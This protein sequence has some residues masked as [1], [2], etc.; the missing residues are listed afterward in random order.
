MGEGVLIEDYLTQVSNDSSEESVL[1]RKLFQ[2]DLRLFNSS[3]GYRMLVLSSINYMRAVMNLEFENYPEIQGISGA[4][5]GIPFNVIGVKK[6]K[7]RRG[8]LFMINPRVV[9]ESKKKTEVVTNCGSVNLKRPV[10]VKRSDWVVVSYYDEDGNFVSGETFRGREGNT[11]QHEIDHNLG[12]LI[13]DG[14]GEEER[15]KK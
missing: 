5:V 6:V 1:R 8:P 10:K 12:T 2:V 11:V 9:S 15:G 13:T 7:G 3:L 4:N 14:T